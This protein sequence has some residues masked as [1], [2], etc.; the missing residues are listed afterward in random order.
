MAII[1][2]FDRGWGLNPDGAAYIQDERSYSFREVGELSC[3][4]A[5][6]LLALGLPQGTKG[7][8]WSGNDVTAWTCTLGLWRANMSW[9]PVNERNAAQENHYILEAFDCEVLFFTC[10]VRR[11]HRRAAS[12]AARDQALDLHRCRRTGCAFAGALVRRPVPRP[13]PKSTSTWTT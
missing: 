11:R 1:D 4:I 8:V 2:F 7:A 6:R 12:A 5:N 3:R 9:I 10:A 13:A